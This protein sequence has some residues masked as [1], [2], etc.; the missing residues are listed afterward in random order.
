MVEV[1]GLDAVVRADAVARSL[2]AETGALGGL[3]GMEATVLVGGLNQVVVLLFRDNE[4]LFGH[5]I[6][7]EV[8]CGNQEGWKNRS[9][10]FLIS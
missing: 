7:E 10:T 4:E 3:V 2:G 8:L 1:E 6:K 9:N 5:G